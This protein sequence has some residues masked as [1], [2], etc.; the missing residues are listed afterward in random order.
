MAPPTST[1]TREGQGP[2]GPSPGGLWVPF[3]NPGGLC[4]A[5]GTTHQFER[6]PPTS[7]GTKG[8]GGGGGTFIV[9]QHG[10]PQGQG[11]LHRCRVIHAPVEQRAR[12]GTGRW[13]T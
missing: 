2:A 5:K 1:S 8:G 6:A 7:L 3:A 10:I 4:P 12:V 13:G 11:I 9:E